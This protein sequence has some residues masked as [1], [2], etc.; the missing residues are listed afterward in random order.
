LAFGQSLRGVA[1]PHSGVALLARVREE[2]SPLSASHPPFAVGILALYASWA[3][4]EYALLSRHGDGYNAGLIALFLQP[5]EIWEIARS[6]NKDGWFTLLWVFRPSG[7]TL[8]VIWALEAL[9]IV[10]FT[11]LMAPTVINGEVFCEACWRWCKSTEEAARLMVPE[12]DA[13]LADLR[14]D[15]LNPLFDLQSAPESANLHLGVDT[16]RCVRC[17]DTAALQIWICASVQDKKGKIHLNAASLTA[18]WS[19]PASVL[20]RIAPDTDWPKARRRRHHL[21]GSDSGSDG[22]GVDF[23]ALSNVRDGAKNGSSDGDLAS[24]NFP[25]DID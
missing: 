13:D 16:W 6:I 15:H 24:L 9:I 5:G 22:S 12:S 8:W 3:A 18:I 2:P 20:A 19:A 25:I 14:A 21:P 17:G 1:Q 4:F 10:G 7:A 23:C 11:C